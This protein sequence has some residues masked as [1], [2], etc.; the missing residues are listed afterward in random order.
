VPLGVEA[1]GA[2]T[3]PVRTRRRHAEATSTGPRPDGLH[4]AATRAG[5]RTPA[6]RDG[7]TP[8]GRGGSTGQPPGRLDRPEETHAGRRL[9]R[10]R[11]CF[12]QRMS[13]RR[14][15]PRGHKADVGRCHPGGEYQ[16]E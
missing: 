5:R 14:P 9:I 10:F 1:S 6:P 7:P 13:G 3:R 12:G 8:L 15:H 2:G 11:T 4:P 16:G